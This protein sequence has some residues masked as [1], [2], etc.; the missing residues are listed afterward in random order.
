MSE[1][2]LGIATAI[3]DVLGRK[4]RWEDISADEITASSG[5]RTPNHDR[6]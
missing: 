5:M 6:T 4:T 3:L 1:H 2:T